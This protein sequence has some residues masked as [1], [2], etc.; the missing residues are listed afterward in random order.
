M[1]SQTSPVSH[2]TTPLPVLPGTAVVASSAPGSGTVSVASASPPPTSIA[3]I[4]QL[5]VGCKVWVSKDGELRH[6]ELLSLV[7]KKSEPYFYVHYTEFN[8]RLDEWVPSTR[9]DLTRPV[10]WP[11]PEKPRKPPGSGPASKNSKDKQPL[12]SNKKNK[13]SRPAPKN[14]KAAKAQQQRARGKENNIVPVVDESQQ[15]KNDV[16]GRFLDG[17][18]AASAVA[19]SALTSQSATPAD[20]K[21]G[22]M[23]DLDSV[24]PETVDGEPENFS[25]E[26][27]IEKLRTSGSMTQSH[28]E[29]A[30]V[31]NFMKVQVGKHEVE[32]W[33]FS[34]YPIELT[35]E[36]CMYVCEFC[37][38][39]FGS[40]KP[41]QRHRVKCHLQ[42][43]P[44]NEI[45]R[46]QSVSF[47]EIDGRRQ[48]TWCRNLCLLSKLFL[49]HKTLY[50]DVDPFLFYCMTVRDE[51]GHHLIGYFSK[52]KESAEQYNVACILTL[53]QY[54]RHGYGKLLIAFSYELSK[55]EGKL[56]SPEKP[57]SDLGLLSYRAF[58]ADTVI[59]LL[60]DEEKELRETTIDEIANMTAMT[61][62]DVLHT[63]QN[64]NMLKYYKG[65]HII[66][67]TNGVME[68]Y[69]KLK[70]KRR[71]KIDPSKLIWKPP[72]FT[73]AQLRFAW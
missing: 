48:R 20:E 30:R 4:G 27:E 50:Y 66:C 73:P 47:F 61:T 3:T 49:D 1:S 35:E 64:L 24:V 40:V 70:T 10:E 69:E 42:H 14:S 59:E 62:T 23:M 18:A 8:K 7:S 53:P 55:K 52:E 12:S 13:R 2:Q 63:L 57:L 25:R 16:N 60:A 34:P 33:Y 29:I 43:P 15:S 21:D 19:A 22:E 26:E 38:S 36:D 11:R 17:V 5:R 65:Q 6:A 39:Y 45:Y 37:L 46:D 71:R 44:G 9:L 58:W 68:H 72:V 51:L 41:F 56:G 31:R 28:H 67:L 54:Q 32:P